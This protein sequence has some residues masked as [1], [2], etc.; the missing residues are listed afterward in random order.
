MGSKE[1]AT[2]RPTTAN[3]DSRLRIRRFGLQRIATSRLG[4]KWRPFVA[5]YRLKKA[6]DHLRWFDESQSFSRATTIFSELFWREYA[7][8][9]ITE[10]WWFVCSQ[11]SRPVCKKKNPPPL[12]TSSQ[13]YASTTNTTTTNFHYTLKQYPLQS[14]L[15]A[16][17]CSCRISQ[18]P[19]KH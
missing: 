18:L 12:R 9:K 16:R 11:L 1:Q 14:F 7:V 10:P 15:F 17:E 2:A 3:N 8:K 5:S 4:L 6:R 13:A 19:Y